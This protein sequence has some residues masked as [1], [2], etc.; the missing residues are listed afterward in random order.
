MRSPRSLAS[1]LEAC[2]RVTLERAGAI[3]AERVGGEVSVNR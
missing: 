2:G 3:L 1:F